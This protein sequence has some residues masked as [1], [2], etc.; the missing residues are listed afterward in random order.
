M[1]RSMRSTRARPGPITPVAVHAAIAVAQIPAAAFV[2]GLPIPI[3]VSPPPEDRS[4]VANSRL[5]SIA[6][7][8]PDRTLSAA[9]VRLLKIEVKQPSVVVRLSHA[10]RPMSNSGT[11]TPKR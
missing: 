4:L 1:S 7:I 10:A 8:A 9:P 6:A 2:V 11:V 3:A 5:R